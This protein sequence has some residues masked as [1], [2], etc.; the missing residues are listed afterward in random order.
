MRRRADQLIA[1]EVDILETALKLQRRGKAEFH[2]YAIAQS[3]QDETGARELLGHGTLY[4][5]LDRLERRGFLTSYWENEAT[6]AAE[7]RP[8]RR[9]YTITAAGQRALAE[10]VAE[11]RQ[12][13]RGRVGR[14]A[15][16]WR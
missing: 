12:T 3:L 4:K 5:A 14:P 7:D 13:T 10:A 15:P 11:E 6:A 9:L 8:P 16:A 1:L 2:G